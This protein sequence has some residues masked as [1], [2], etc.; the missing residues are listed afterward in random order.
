MNRT[1]FPHPHKRFGAFRRHDQTP[2]SQQPIQE[3]PITQ[4]S[5]INAVKVK[6]PTA[7]PQTRFGQSKIMI[8]AEV[9]GGLTLVGTAFAAIKTD[10]F[11]L[12][13]NNSKTD[14]AITTDAGDLGK[15]TPPTLDN[16]KAVVVGETPTASPTEAPRATPTPEKIKTVPWT[17]EEITKEQNEAL[18]DNKIIYLDT[19][20]TGGGILE[21]FKNSLDKPLLIINYDTKP[22]GKTLKSPISG[23]VTG[24]GLTVSGNGAKTRAIFIT[25][26]KVEV[27]FVVDVDS[28]VNVKQDQK[29]TTGTDL[30]T[31]S[32]NPI[33]EGKFSKPGY[34]VFG[35]VTNFTSTT[36]DLLRDGNGTLVTLQ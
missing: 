6:T 14:K 26:G 3:N 20:S 29:I 30:I 22:E 12:F 17:I 33:P 18:A 2:R 27:E 4:E 35:D 31:L 23:T 28:T 1:E 15:G 32:G 8:G 34:V 36:Q 9:V 19:W 16:G 13:S 7:K 25:N 5:V 10:A 24:I 21:G 11:G